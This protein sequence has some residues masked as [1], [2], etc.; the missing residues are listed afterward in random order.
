MEKQTTKEIEG[1]L[2]SVL[3]PVEILKHEFLVAIIDAL[4]Y[5]Y[6]TT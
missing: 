2:G 5:F 3:N 1:L 4:Q 6:K